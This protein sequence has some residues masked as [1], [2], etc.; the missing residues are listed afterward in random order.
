MVSGLDWYVTFW[1]STDD[2]SLGNFT[3]RL[4]PSGSRQLIVRSGSTVKFRSGPW[5]GLRFSIRIS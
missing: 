2:P 3:Y 5:N 4:D 1:R